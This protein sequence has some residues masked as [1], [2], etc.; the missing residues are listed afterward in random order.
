MRFENLNKQIQLSFMQR[1]IGGLET[2]RQTDRKTNGRTDERTDV[3][4]N[5]PMD[6]WTESLTSSVGD[7]QTLYD[8]TISFSMHISNV[9]L[10]IVL[11]PLS[12]L[13]SIDHL[14]LHDSQKQFQVNW[15]IYIEYQF[16]IVCHH[17]VFIA[18]ALIGINGYFKLNF[19]PP[20]REKFLIQ[21]SLEDQLF[22]V[23]LLLSII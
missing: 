20:L 2:D 23:S 5:G 10:I 16:C 1:L 22:K 11:C 13:S 6:E 8:T 19:R 3:R 14:V 9:I 21:L 18:I 12:F 17:C 15:K 4:T 7:R